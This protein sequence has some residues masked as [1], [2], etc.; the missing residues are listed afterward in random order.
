M[1]A[2][3]RERGPASREDLPVALRLIVRSCPQHHADQLEDDLGV[4]I[5]RVLAREVR[6]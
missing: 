4:L 3:L 6:P 2:R 5:D 1:Q